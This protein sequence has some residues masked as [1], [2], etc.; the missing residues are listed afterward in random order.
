MYL[1]IFIELPL[2]LPM[3]EERRGVD[4]VEQ[5]SH[6]ILFAYY[7]VDR[8]FFIEIVTGWLY[9]G[10]NFG[11]CCLEV[12]LLKRGKTVNIILVDVEHVF[13]L[14]WMEE[15]VLNEL[16]NAYLILDFWFR[17]ILVLNI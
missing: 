13:G 8:H 1:G 7:F 4:W 10:F 6:S 17:F 12:E 5:S 15:L 9:F 3:R 14:N 16:W 11:G 2:E